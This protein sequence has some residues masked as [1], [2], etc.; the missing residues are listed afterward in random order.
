M[1]R[2]LQ[3]RAG[4]R[5]EE[6]FAFQFEEPYYITLGVLYERRP[7]FAGGAF[8][9]ILRPVDNF[10]QPRFP[11]RM[12]SGRPGRIRSKRPMPS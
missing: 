11:R 5:S 7:R 3:V 10:L 8:S 1:Y 2:A 4:H 6:A 9:P 12:Q